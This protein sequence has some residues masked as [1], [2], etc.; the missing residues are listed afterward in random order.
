MKFQ[1]GMV[2]PLV[3]LFVGVVGF[4]L[5]YAFYLSVTDYKL[6][7]HGTPNLVGANNY[8]NT[9]G[10]AVQPID[11]AHLPQGQHFVAGDQRLFQFWYRNP[12][13]GGAGFNLSDGLR[14]TFCP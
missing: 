10:D 7:N 3:A 1:H 4:P 14:V 13:A 12:S 5:A 2:A 6:T 11:L 9:F 8:V